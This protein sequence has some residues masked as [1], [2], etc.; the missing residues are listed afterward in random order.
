VNKDKL[1]DGLLTGALRNL[2]SNAEGFLQ[3]TFEAGGVEILVRLLLSGSPVAQANASYLLTNLILASKTSS[4]GVN[5]I[6][7]VKSLL[8]IFLVLKMM[9][10]YMLKQLVHYKL[11]LPN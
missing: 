11:F 6:G 5:K 8:K 2:C 9:Y 1:I 7:T 4:V 10:L 3:A